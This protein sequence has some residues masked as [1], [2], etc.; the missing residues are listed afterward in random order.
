VP[1]HAAELSDFVEWGLD[2]VVPDSPDVGF[3]YW[4]TLSWENAGKYQADLVIVDERYYPSNL[5]QAE[6]QP[7]WSFI[8]AVASDA[9]AVWP[10]FWVRNHA[11]YAWALERLTAAIE[12]A[13]DQLVTRQ[14]SPTR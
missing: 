13:D 12:S 8:D 7:T 3:E 10:A 2:I 4:E 5:E 1:E 6:A 11:D 9:V 14:S